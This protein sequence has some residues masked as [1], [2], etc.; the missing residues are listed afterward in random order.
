M[1]SSP[2]LV[3]VIF[4]LF[5][6]TYG[7][8]VTQEEGQVTLSEEAF[9]TINC[10]Y[11]ATG[12]PALF[13]YVQYPGE[14]PQLLVTAVKANDK[15]INKGFEA[16]YK[17]ET[18]SFHLQKASVHESDSAVYYCA[19]SDTVTGAAGGADGTFNR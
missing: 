8:T 4:L 1:N 2:G 17:R 14:G 9:L 7:N 5:G 11:T 6:R 3:T 15:G 12:Y 16:T 10:T 19:L 18:T 13:W